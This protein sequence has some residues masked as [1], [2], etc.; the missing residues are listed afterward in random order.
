MEK[1]RFFLE[2][3]EE[4]ADIGSWEFDF[5]SGKVTASPGACRIYGIIED[6]FT[7]EAVEKVPL[8]E[9]RANL[10]E[11][12]EALIK[13]GVPY[14]IEFVI[15]RGG[16]RAVRVIHSKARW[17]SVN[18]RLFGI[19]R[20]ITEERETAAGLKQAIAEKETLI[21][22]LYHRTKNN[23]QIITS[24]LG[25]EGD[26]SSDLRVRYVFEEVQ[27]RIEAMALVH[28][29]LYL[30]N[31]LSR[32]DLKDFIPA[33]A[34]LLKSS[35]GG[36][37]GQIDF[38]YEINEVALL[39]DAAVPCGII[40]NELISNAL[41]HAFPGER[42]GT[43]TLRARREDEG[44]VLIEVKDDGVGVPTAF[45]YREGGVSMGLSLVTSIVRYQ[46][47]G[48]VDIET[49]GSGFG[50]TLRFTDASYQARV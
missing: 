49:G 11:A 30:S 33:L 43:I 24:L 7:I 12:R 18:H 17:D 25:I 21:K 46:L 23:M 40:L 41:I 27:R 31:D 48:T 10:D 14:D 9:Y 19:I 45:D 32:I 16:D 22:E 3:A 39:I 28:E 34:E 15:E 37:N 50:C 42:S 20:D 44:T 4:M 2:R 5:L 29:M 38:A 1:S 35:L 26:R 36:R 6:A 13:Y 8:P 47:K